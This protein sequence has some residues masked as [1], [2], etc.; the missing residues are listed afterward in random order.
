MSI[1]YQQ[2]NKMKIKRSKTEKDVLFYFVASKPNPKL[3]KTIQE[4][5]K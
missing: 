2:N 1:R 4:T 5:R 3:K